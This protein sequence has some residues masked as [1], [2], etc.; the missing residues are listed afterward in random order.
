MEVER[1]K[2]DKEEGK[3]NIMHSESRSRGERNKEEEEEENERLKR[4]K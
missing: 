4:K 3:R 2:I 1:N